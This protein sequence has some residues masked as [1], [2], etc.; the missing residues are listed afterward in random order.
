MGRVRTYKPIPKEEVTQL[1]DDISKM[2]DNNKSKLLDE[3]LGCYDL[4]P[5]W[6]FLHKL[7]FSKMLI[8]G[9]SRK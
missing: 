8:D 4:K 1:L 6:E 9:D 5:N 3:L 2:S 7:Q